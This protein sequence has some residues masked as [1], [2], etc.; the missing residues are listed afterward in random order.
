MHYLCATVYYARYSEWTHS[1]T[2]LLSQ[3]YRRSNLFDLV[4]RQGCSCST[5]LPHECGIHVE[6]GCPHACLP[7]AVHLCLICNKVAIV[8]T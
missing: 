8:L 7:V 3:R 4:T 5:H 2:V 6:D 1:C